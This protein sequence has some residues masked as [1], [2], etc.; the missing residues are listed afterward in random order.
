MKYTDSPLFIYAAI[1][2]D[3]TGASARKEIKKIREGKQPVL[4][5]TLTFDEVF[6]K[7]KKEKGQEAALKAGKAFLEMENVAFVD[8]T[9]N[10]LWRAYELIE[11]YSLDPR[12]AIHAACALVRGASVM[13]S[14]DKDFDRITEIKREWP[15]AV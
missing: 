8:V 5:S 2:S 15:L 1:S 11:S 4:T 14:E 6:W 12:D 3:E 9:D 7:V 10:V 13:I